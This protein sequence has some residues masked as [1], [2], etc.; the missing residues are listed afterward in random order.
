MAR[1]GMVIDLRRCVGCGTCALACKAEHNTRTRAGGQSFNWADFVMKTE[2][3]FPNVTQTVLPVLCNHCTDA[4]C[5]KACPVTPKAMYKTPEGITLHDNALCI[6]C[7]SC[8]MACPYSHVELTD[9][10]LS[11]ETY[12]VISFNSREGDAQPQWTSTSVMIAGCTSSGAETAKAAGAA[13]PAMNQY[14]AGDVQPIRKT[15][16]VEKCTLCY[17][18]TSNGLQPACVEACPAKAR[19]FGDQDDPNSE[20]AKVLKA[21]KSFRLQEKK[22]TKPNVHYIG[23]Y[24]ARV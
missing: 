2:G 15:G 1:F 20:I 5:V 12:S 22:G 21:E 16:I 6:G 11:G 4:A 8:Q 7:R 19:I 13:T 14:E 3:K 24:S 17:H 18:R 23:K 9:A 10:S